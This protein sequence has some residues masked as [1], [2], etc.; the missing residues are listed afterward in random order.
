MKKR[1]VLSSIAGIC[2]TFCLVSTLAFCLS[3]N[4]DVAKGELP[5][6]T[7]TLDSNQKITTSSTPSGSEISEYVQTAKNNN[8]LLSAFNVINNASGWQ[9]ILPGGYVYNPYTNATDHNQISGL[10]SFK[11]IGNGSLELHYGYTSDTD[12]IL[13]SFERTLTAGVEYSIEDCSPSYFYLKNV[14]ES[15]VNISSLT[16]KYS[17][18]AESYPLNNLKILMIG[19]SFADDTVYYAARVASS[20]GINLEIYDAYIG[21]CTLNTHYTNIQSGE[22]LYSMRSMN[23]STWNYQNEMS[24]NDIVTYKPW[25]IITFQQASAE[26]GRTGTYNNLTNL[27][28]EVKNLVTGNPKYYWHQTWAYDQ[29]YSEYYDYFSYFNN[30][31]DTMFNALV[32]CYNN[33]VVPTGLFEKTIFNGT[34]VQNLRTSYMKNSFSRDGKHMSLVHG[35]YLL[36]YNFISSVYGIDFE[37]SPVPY[38]PEGMNRSYHTV[39]NESIKNARLHP[40]NITSSN[41][42]V[43]EMADYDLSNYTEIDAGLVGCSFWNCT[44]SSNYNN[45]FNHTSGTSNIYCTTKRFTSSTLPV[46]SMIFCQEGLGF[47]PEAWVT[48]AK[49]DSRKVEQYDNVLVID[50]DFWNGYQYR[51]FNI[52]KSGKQKLAGDYT[53][54]QYDDIFDGFR[55]FVPNSKMAGLTPKNTNSYYSADSSLFSAKSLNIDNYDRIHLDPITGFYKCDSYYYLMNSYVDD[56]AQRFVCTRPFVTADGDLPAGTVLIVDSGYQWRSD[57]W[58][59]RSTNTRP[60]NV[61]TNVTVLDSSFMS[62]YRRR[63]FNVSKTD[64]YTKVGQNSIDFMNH[65]RIYVPKA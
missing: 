60:G 21:G 64:G 36:S 37:L 50:N 26:I 16:I 32:S 28:N 15:N 12:E 13:Y 10:T 29:D 20:L 43:G 54:E 65:F 8:V 61:S 56:T 23:G 27:V 25:D 1:V 45:R 49:Q 5:S 52:F 53:D 57:C 18:V 55:I 14:G 7:L 40:D 35:R 59:E 44:D 33:Y 31:S 3:K 24:L 47:R 42:P 9:T 63:T 11:Y 4:Y 34:A 46:G 58:T 17:C 41:Y 6:Q 48:D 2:G 22:A 30:D 19:N 51:A 62:P 38:L 39:L